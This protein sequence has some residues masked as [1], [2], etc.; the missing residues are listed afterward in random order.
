MSEAPVGRWAC[1]WLAAGPPGLA[2]GMFVR[3]HP[4]AVT[5][6]D[7]KARAAPWRR[8]VRIVNIDDLLVSAP[9]YT[10][11][12]S[13][14][15]SGVGYAAASGL[16]LNTRHSRAMISDRLRDL[17]PP[18]ARRVQC[19]LCH[20]EHRV[21]RLDAGRIP[22]VRVLPCQVLGADHV[23]TRN[24]DGGI[25]R[26]LRQPRAQCGICTARKGNVTLAA[27][28]RRRDGQNGCDAHE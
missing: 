17:G 27:G 15:A 25:A 23:R 9:S 16:H 14:A 13:F 6:S 28:R 11:L 2:T 22:E 1:A 19:P 21:R 12:A 4:A 18:R 5:A 8:S 20:H 24:D 7:I 10:M 3:S 26:L